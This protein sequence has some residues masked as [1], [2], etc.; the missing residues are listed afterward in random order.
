MKRKLLRYGKAQSCSMLSEVVIIS[1][2]FIMTFIIVLPWMCRDWV[3]SPYFSGKPSNMEYVDRAMVK[4]QQRLEAANQY[5]KNNNN[6]QGKHAGDSVDLA[7]VIIG[8][9][10]KKNNVTPDYLVQTATELHKQTTLDKLFPSKRTLICGVDPYPNDSNLVRTCA[11]LYPTLERFGG[12][13]P[14]ETTTDDIFEKSK[15]DYAFCM[16]RG[17][18]YNPR[19]VLVIE[20]DALVKGNFF[21]VVYHLLYTELPLLQER[22]PATSRWA[23]LKLYYPSKWAGYSNNTRHHAERIGIALI[24][25]TLFALVHLLYTS[26]YP[27]YPRPHLRNRCWGPRHQW[28]AVGAVY[29]LLLCH[30]V[31]RPYLLELLTTSPSLTKLVPSPGCCTPA[32]LYPASVVPPLSRHLYTTMSIAGRSHDLIMDAWADQGGYARIM[33]EPSL[34]HHIGLV[35]T[36]RQWA[37]KAAYFIY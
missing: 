11:K 35:S 18:D 7:I 23:F 4:N 32:V 36:V 21:S 2:L 1:S 24:G 31:G 14:N 12:Q 33:A 3:H 9:D 8:M 29:F 25:G 15:E 17:M 27:S 5:L 34:V 28:F 16:Q 37:K 22:N 6:I 30:A 10:R 19:Y 13:Y 20:D 26:V